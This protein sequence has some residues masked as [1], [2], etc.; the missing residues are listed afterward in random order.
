MKMKWFIGF[1]AAV[2]VLA[3]ASP[4]FAYDDVHPYPIS[5]ERAEALMECN[6][7]ASAVHPD[8]EDGHNRTAYYRACMYSHDQPE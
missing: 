7:E 3:S 4:G 2:S 1:V 8:Y 6:Y 5:H